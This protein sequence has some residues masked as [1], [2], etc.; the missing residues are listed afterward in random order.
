MSPQPVSS[1]QA[2]DRPENLPREAESRRTRVARQELSAKGSDIDNTIRQLKLEL[3][4]RYYAV[5]LGKTQHGLAQE[6]LTQFDQ[7]VELNEARFKRG[8]ISGL[9]I[10]RV[11]AERLRFLTDVLN[12]DLEL[13]N[14]KTALLELLGVSDFAT[15]FDVVEPLASIG[16]QVAS[17]E[18]QAQA[19][20]SRPDLLAAQQR[21][22]RDRSD[23]QLQT[24]CRTL[25]QRANQEAIPRRH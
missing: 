24:R 6:N 15:Q 14:A 23:V 12:A 3:K 7:V 2:G 4:L 20:R 19:L 11:R 13:K 22:E 9:D 25:R 16:P 17:P 21:L 8:E 5:V 1:G 18:L 10:S